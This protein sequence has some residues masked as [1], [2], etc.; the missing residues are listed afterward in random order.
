MIFAQQSEGV[1][2][3]PGAVCADVFLRATRLARISNAISS[4]PRK[5][6]RIACRLP[7]LLLVTCANYVSTESC[8]CANVYAL[9]LLCDSVST[10]DAVST[11][12]F[13]SFYSA[14]SCVIYVIPRVSAITYGEKS[15]SR[16]SSHFLQVMKAMSILRI[17]I[18]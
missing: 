17:R 4:Q 3:F 2:Y 13:F 8:A 7:A 6:E 14:Y 10:L 16:I 12:H 11:S 18:L 9:L 15:P 1:V 5:N